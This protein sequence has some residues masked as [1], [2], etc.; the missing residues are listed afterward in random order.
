MDLS[1]LSANS[2]LAS[3]KQDER[4]IL[5]LPQRY[6]SSIPYYDIT[7]PEKPQAA[8]VLGVTQAGKL[9]WE[10]LVLFLTLRNCFYVPYVTVFLGKDRGRWWE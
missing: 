6:N 4:C 9:R 1:S 3:E 5:S 2:N 8:C 10:A 7:S